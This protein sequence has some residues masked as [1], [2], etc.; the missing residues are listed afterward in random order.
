MIIHLNVD[1]IQLIHQSIQLPLEDLHPFP[2][3][4][5]KMNELKG[6]PRLQDLPELLVDPVHSQTC[7]SLHPGSPQAKFERQPTL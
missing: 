7:I 6:V 1:L 2:Y 5:C 3:E 4:I